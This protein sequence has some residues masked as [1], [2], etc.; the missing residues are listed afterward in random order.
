MKEQAPYIKQN[1]INATKEAE[2]K[3][4]IW[5]KK[6]KEVDLKKNNFDERNSNEKKLCMAG[7]TFLTNKN[8]HKSR[9]EGN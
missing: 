7:H 5:L 6:G 1:K 2:T 4:L 9:R 3:G 8:C